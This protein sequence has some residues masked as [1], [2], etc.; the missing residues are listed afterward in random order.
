[1]QALVIPL[2]AGCNTVSNPEVATCLRTTGTDYGRMLRAIMTRTLWSG[3]RFP[4][5]ALAEKIMYEDLTAP[6]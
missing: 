1:M 6:P 2:P 3:P 5:R 4:Q